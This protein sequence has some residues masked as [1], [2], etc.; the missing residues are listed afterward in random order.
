MMEEVTP[1]YFGWTEQHYWQ[2]VALP[3]EPGLEP[4]PLSDYEQKRYLW[5]L[6]RWLRCQVV[7]EDR[8]RRLQEGRRVPRLIPV[9]DQ[10]G[11]QGEP[12]TLTG[13]EEAL[14]TQ[15]KLT[16]QILP[17]LAAIK[18]LEQQKV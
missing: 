12:D 11:S 17:I 4:A 3:D 16:V 7:R 15:E 1:Q 6:S 2:T 5:P 13:G 14:S 8:E 18:E 9:T 10:Q